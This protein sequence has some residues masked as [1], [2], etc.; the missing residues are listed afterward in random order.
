M[1]SRHLLAVLALIFLTAIQSAPGPAAAMPINQGAV[2]PWQNAVHR[3]NAARD[4]GDLQVDEAALLRMQAIRDPAGLP[5]AYQPD[6]SAVKEPFPTIHLDGTLALAYRIGAVYEDQ[7]QWSEATRQAIERQLS[8]RGLGTTPLSGKNQADL[9]E[10][11][12]SDHFIIHWAEQG[13]DAPAGGDAYIESI[14]DALEFAWDHFGPSG[15]A[16]ILPDPQDYRPP[17]D[18]IDVFI[19]DSIEACGVIPLDAAGLA[20][21]GKITLRNDIPQDRISTLSAHEL[22]HLIQYRYAGFFETRCPLVVE[23]EIWMAT[24]NGWFVEASASWAEDEAHPSDNY[25]TN[26]IASYLSRPDVSL[27]AR[28]DAA[29][30]NHEYG[31]VVFVKFL[32]EHITPGA[33][34]SNRN[35]IVRAIWENV[36]PQGR[37]TTDAVTY[38]LQNPPSGDMPYDDYTDTWKGIFDEFAIANLLKD[39][40]DSASWPGGAEVPFLENLAPDASP[41]VPLFGDRSGFEDPAAIYLDIS[42][43]NLGLP[44]GAD[45]TG[46]TLRLEFNTDCSECTLD[47]VHFGPGGTTSRQP[48]ALA[49]SGTTPGL[50]PIYSVEVDLETGFGL[51]NSVG[52]VSLVFANGAIDGF[53][54]GYFDYRIEAI[55][56]PPIRPRNFRVALSGAEGVQLNWDPVQEAGVSYKIYRSQNSPIPISGGT[57]LATTSSNSYLDPNVQPGTR[58][59]YVVS[60]VD[61]GGN[62]GPTSNEVS[63]LVPAPTPTPTTPPIGTTVT[64]TII[65]GSDDAGPNAVP[66]FGC[67]YTVSWNEI[68]FGE[69]D[70]GTNVTSGFRFADVAIPAGASIT[71]ARVDF[72]VNGPYDNPLTL[73]IYGED[74]GDAPTFSTNSRPAG[75]PLTT[76]S[77][78]WHIPASDHWGLNQERSTPDLTGVIQEIVDRSDWASGNSLGLI[79]TNDSPAGGLH[80]RVIGFERPTS[81]YSGHL[82]EL[83]VT[84]Q[85]EGPP[86]PTPTATAAPTL[87]PTPT[88]TA[89]PFSCNCA[90]LCLLDSSS[91][92]QTE[93]SLISYSPRSGFFGQLRQQVEWVDLLRR[94]RDEVM[95]ETPEGRR[96]MRLY[97]RHSTE[98]ASIMLQDE[99][100]RQQ[101]FATIELFVPAFE[102]LL[103]GNGDQV[104]ITTEQVSAVEAFLAN[105]ADA[106]P[107]L[108]L[109]IE[110]ELAR[111]SLKDL[112]GRSMDEAWGSL[113]GYSLE[114]LPPSIP[115]DGLP[116]VEN[117]GR[118][119]PV[120]FA[121]RDIAGEPAVDHSVQLLVLDI[122][123]TVVHGPVEVGRNPNSSIKI[124]NGRYQHN[125]QTKGLGPGTY[126]IRIRFNNV[127]R[128]Q[129]AALWV[130]LE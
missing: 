22:F 34:Y 37:S 17:Q 14:A 41:T 113:N 60:A 75:R 67:S 64:A 20:G 68:Y 127:V 119:L 49:V 108:A 78:I 117:A 77:S 86:P 7:N 48:H 107:Q 116:L 31:A 21:P 29:A 100:L 76:S 47:S 50:R 27:F 52:R 53:S 54:L 33:G 114:W 16:Y 9:P 32:E 93:F 103:N 112:A 99:A 124:Q 39:Y 66:G 40:E 125:W 73:R 43:A 80:R 28:R 63:I 42:S 13:E 79:F 109:V 88:P 3:I 111:Q 101:G 12:E 129:P 69:C 82:A 98:L 94:V 106:S 61:V 55:D 65:Q 118:T 62:E 2:E 1:K 23:V 84:Y 10:S 51:A 91:T 115:N 25:Y 89:T 57:H 71:S 90:I 15:L 102:A 126:I 4:K 70:D 58:Y 24:G 30:P 19:V 26:F 105:V 18:K 122:H 97:E 121:L 92:A 45:A 36:L 81:T 120:R 85:L 56:N 96:Y 87:M 44:G 128:G 35:D 95:V 38:V 6:P 83:V 8:P 104:T 11:F 59:Y 110:D 5:E 123:G 130:Y 72:T 74:S 46:A